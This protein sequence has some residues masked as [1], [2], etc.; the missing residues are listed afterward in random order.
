MV[1]DQGNPKANF[2]DPIRTSKR[3]TIV[4]VL[5]LFRQAML[6]CSPFLGVIKVRHWGG[7]PL[8][9]HLRGDFDTGGAS[10]LSFKVFDDACY[11]GWA[12]NPNYICLVLSPNGE[13]TLAGG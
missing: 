9:Y 5:F 4:H 8:T 6:M 2:K 7:V 12:T 3:H 11:A 1:S 13:L 10:T